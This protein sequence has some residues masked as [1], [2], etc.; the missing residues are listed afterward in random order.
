MQ[1]PS[2]QNTKA[3]RQPRRNKAFALL[4]ASIDVSSV[5]LSVRVPTLVLHR[6]AMCRCRSNTAA[7]WP[8]KIPGARLIK[9]SGNDHI[10]FLATVGAR[11]ATS[12]NS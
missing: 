1:S 8:Q 2:L 12:K 10:P 7:I 9:Y 11:L 4:N 5:L 3:C 6:K